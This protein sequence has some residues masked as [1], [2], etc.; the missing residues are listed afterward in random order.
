MRLRDIDR[1]RRGRGLIT[2]AALLAAC[3]GPAAA[4]ASS[5]PANLTAPSIGGTA[6]DGGHLKA[7]KG[8]WSG[9]RP[10]TYAYQWSRCDAS[11]EGCAPISGA[12]AASYRPGHEDVGHELRVDVSTTDETGTS[13]ATS[14]PTAA[15]AAQG[16]VKRTSPV[17]SGLAQ[18]GQLL[19]AGGGTW[20]GTPP[21]K[22]SYRWESCNVTGGACAVIPGAE[23][24]QYRVTTPQI[25]HRLRALVTASNAAGQAS[26]T[27]HAG[28]RV[29][30]GSPVNTGAPVVTG[31]LLEGGA[32]TA[33]PGEWAGT[34]PFSFAY[35]WQRCSDLGGGCEE[36]PGATGSTYPLGV[37]DIGSRLTVTVTATNTQGSVSAVSAETDPVL[38]N[39]PASTELPSISGLLQDGGLL[40]IAPGAWSGTGPISYSYQWQLCDALGKACSD[41]GGATGSTLPLSAADVG[42]TLDVVVKATNVAGSTSVTTPVTG[43]ISGA[44]AGEH[45]AAVASRA[46]PAGWLVC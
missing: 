24:A 19:T 37:G 6:R 12:R 15:V 26:A 14:A 31:G 4:Q 43:L 25:G 27:S 11:G 23:A 40:G 13:S 33:Q 20:K 5:G 28:R 45:G 1:G 44:A 34:G 9:Q 7:F 2:A 41:I 32:L 16:P 8:T 10:L 3:I 17:V 38:G 21:L 36:V 42:A 30:P 35:Q 29:G 39:L 18:D 22:L 46:C